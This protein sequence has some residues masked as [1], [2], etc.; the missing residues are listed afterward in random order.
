MIRVYPHRGVDEIRF[1]M[2]R[3][4]V[5]AELGE[6]SEKSVE[7]NAIGEEE[8]EW[9]YER[10]AMTL[11]FARRDGYRLGTITLD[12]EDVEILDGQPIGKQ[13]SEL[14]GLF[15][16]QPDFA[17]RLEDEYPTIKARD[18]SCD[19]LGLLFMIVNGVTERVSLFPAYVDGKAVWLG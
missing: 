14:L 15:E 8:V 3:H 2:T 16:E 9:T 17:L 19:A 1:G 12:S 11:C 10:Y 13:E 5:V 6:P 7:T 18:Y 4:Q